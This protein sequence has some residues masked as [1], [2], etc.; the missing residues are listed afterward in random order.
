MRIIQGYKGNYL[1]GN[2]EAQLQASAWQWKKFNPDDELVL[3]CP[4]HDTDVAFN[5]KEEKSRPWDKICIVPDETV[6]KLYDTVRYELMSVQDQDFGWL[7]PDT[8][9]F[10]KIP[11]LIPGEI[12]FIGYGNEGGECHYPDIQERPIWDFLRQFKYIYKY[13][14]KAYNMGFFKTTAELGVLIGEECQRG[15]DFFR[16]QNPTLWD[17]S[18]VR[19]HHFCSQAIPALV[20]DR[21]G[22]KY[23]CIDDLFPNLDHP[24]V[25]HLVQPFVEM[26]N[27]EKLWSSKRN[28]ERAGFWNELFPYIVE[29][30][31]ITWEEFCKFYYDH[32]DDSVKI[33]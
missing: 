22:K 9:T 21:F 14:G 4:R 2:K 32:K 5:F 12:D 26:P 24:A 28:K 6:K 20:I 18:D 11:N 33:I 3:Y 17:P 25:W 27:G 8:L 1:K 19:Q 15:L 16:K 31:G 7:D 29:K 13:E 10:E 23:R 30:Q